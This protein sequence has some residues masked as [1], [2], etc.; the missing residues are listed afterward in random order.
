MNSAGLLGMVETHWSIP[1]WESKSLLYII[2]NHNLSLYIYIC[3]YIYIY[4]YAK[5]LVNE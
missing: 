1:A 5:F 2:H 3:I 4:I